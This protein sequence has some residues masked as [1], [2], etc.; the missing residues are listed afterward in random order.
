MFTSLVERLDPLL[1]GVYRRLVQLP[2]PNLKGDRDLEYSWVAAHL[3]DGPGEAMDFGCGPSWMGLLAARK[4]FRVTAVD[5][6]P[7]TWPYRHAGLHFVQGDIFD[8]RFPRDHFDLILNCSSIEHVGLGGRYDV[9]TSRSDGDLEAM[10]MFQ[11]MTK[12][13]KAM[14]LTIPVGRDRVF[15]PLHRVYGRERL[16]KLLTGWDVVKSEFWMKDASNVWGKSDR[17]SAL[18]VEPTERYYAL[19]LF[20]LRRPENTPQRISEGT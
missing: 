19:G 5:L 8:L 1:K 9:T 15:P 13:G 2:V 14:L 11:Q 18:D 7:V 12:P 4:G 6:L 16:P 10:G 17:A 3:P 20:V